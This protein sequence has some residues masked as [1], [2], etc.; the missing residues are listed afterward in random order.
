VGAKKERRPDNSGL[1]HW[2]ARMN[3]K[4]YRVDAEYCDFLQ[5]TD[6]CVPHAQNEKNMRPFVGILLTEGGLDYFAP[7]SSPKPKHKNMKNQLDFL[8]INGG[9]WGAINFNNMIP[10]HPH[11]VVAVDM[12]ISA[13]DAEADVSYKRLLANQL[14]WCNSNKRGI[15]ERATKLYRMVVSKQARPELARRCCDFPR[16]E[17]QCRAWCASHGLE[18]PKMT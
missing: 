12:K 8:R 17:E 14:S 7:L 6:P 10:I 2:V 18:A 9:K 16:D 15:M 4:F 11:C 3:L 5:K 13:T 1:S